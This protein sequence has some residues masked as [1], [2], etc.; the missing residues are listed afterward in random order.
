MSEKEITSVS[1]NFEIAFLETVNDVQ[2]DDVD[3]HNTGPS[4]F[5]VERGVQ[6]TVFMIIFMNKRREIFIGK[7]QKPGLGRVFFIS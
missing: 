7:E 5:L 4:S 2:D 3:E 1:K 6:V